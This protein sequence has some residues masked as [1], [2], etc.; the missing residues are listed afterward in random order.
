MF[1]VSLSFSFLV[2]VSL[3]LLLLVSTL[4]M[5]EMVTA[6]VPLLDSTALTESDAS[7]LGVRE[8]AQSSSQKNL[9][10]GE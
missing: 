7:C 9:R 1:Y 5:Q 3:F 2:S 10:G 8:E 4:L 6:N